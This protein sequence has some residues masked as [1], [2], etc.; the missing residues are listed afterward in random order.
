MMKPKSLKAGSRVALIAPSS[1]VSEGKLQS[2]LESLKF[3]RLEPVMFPSCTMK[4]GYLSGSDSCRAKD[5]NDAFQDESIDGIFCIRGG[6]GATRLLPLIDY[7]IIKNNPKIFVG[8]S[9]ITALHCVFNKLCGFITIHGP[10]PNTGYHLMD[11]YS[12]QSLS[13]LIFSNEAIGI[14]I[15][16]PNEY[17]ETIYPGVAEG[18]ITGGNLSVMVSALGSPYEIDTKD[19]ILFIEDVDEPPYRIDRNLTALALAGK[20]NDCK[21]IILGTFDNCIESKGEPTL[22]LKEIFEEIIVPFKKPTIYNFRSGHIYPQI[23][24][25]MGAKTYLDAT[26]NIVKFY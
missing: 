13:D 24:I 15:N 3:L 11:Y 22:S 9:D 10:M 5:I 17:I 8:Y 26:H 21:G 2:S 6:Y 14:V 18:I 19:K 12:L 1:P 4:N 23:S 7:S 16:P 25:P 20:L